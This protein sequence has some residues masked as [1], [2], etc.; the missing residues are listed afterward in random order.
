[1]CVQHGTPIQDFILSSQYPTISTL[2]HVG[3]YTRP[4]GLYDPLF[5]PSI[6]FRASHMLDPPQAPS[7]YILGQW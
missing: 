1:M 3:N 2:L 7:F 4:L 5:A 6:P